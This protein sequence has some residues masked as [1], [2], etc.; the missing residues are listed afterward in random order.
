MT[1][2]SSQVLFCPFCTECFEEE[3]L[4][5]HHELKLVPFEQ[6]PTTGKSRAYG[7]SEEVPWWEW[8]LGRGWLWASA[9]TMLISFFQP[10]F[11]LSFG[12]AFV[13]E[14]AFEIVMRGEADLLWSIP[15]IALLLAYLPW[16]RSSPVAMTRARLAV[17]LITLFP[18]PMVAYAAIVAQRA[19]A[20]E[21]PDALLEFSYGVFSLG[22]ALLL[23]LIGAVRFG[24]QRPSNT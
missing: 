3:T 19:S 21:T 2:P 8:K 9:I 6:L 11:A 15:A 13:Q 18:A 14:S 10:L 16:R 7:P 20:L 5:P 24:H 23:G 4:C 17:A 12:D 1:A 22:L